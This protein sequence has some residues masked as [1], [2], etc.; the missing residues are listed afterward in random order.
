MI[1][2][3]KG[4]HGIRLSTIA[5]LF[6]YSI[7]A[8]RSLRTPIELVKVARQYK[9]SNLCNTLPCEFILNMT[10]LVMAPAKT[11]MEGRATFCKFGSSNIP[12]CSDGSA[13]HNLGP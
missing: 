4:S 3:Y 13:H 5:L 12:N 8:C 6:N 2:V 7:M 11:T 9:S 1:V 10:S